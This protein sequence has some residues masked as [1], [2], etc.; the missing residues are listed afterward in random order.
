MSKF[1]NTGIVSVFS[2]P[3]KANKVTK[4]EMNTKMR[5]AQILKT[6]KA[7]MDKDNVIDMGVYRK[8]YQEEYSLI[9]HY[10]GSVDAALDLIGGIKKIR[11]EKDNGLS[12][13]NRLAL[14][15]I[16]TLRDSGFSFDDIAEK[17]QVSKTAVNNLYHQ[18]NK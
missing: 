16:D 12:L 9:N 11:I 15:M 18:L 10:F 17:Y 2:T 5:K 3:V 14:D 7:S 8:H 6:L 13:R 1:D 4:R